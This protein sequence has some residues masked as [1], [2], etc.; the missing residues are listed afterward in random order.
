MPSMSF[1]PCNIENGGEYWFFSRLWKLQ[2]CDSTTSN[3][4]K[5]KKKHRSP[6]PS[7]QVI[8][9][10][11]GMCRE[12]HS[13]ENSLNCKRSGECTHCH[14]QFTDKF[15]KAPRQTFTFTFKGWKH[16]LRHWDTCRNQLYQQI[17]SW[18]AHT[19]DLRQFVAIT[20]SSHT[21]N[22]LSGTNTIYKCSRP[23]WILLP[24]SEWIWSLN[25]IEKWTKIKFIAE[26]N[27]MQ[28]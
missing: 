9:F 10:L 3:S 18:V 25:T 24:L 5:K 2:Y 22:F 4:L 7:Q 20:K 26:A 21:S 15:Q 12:E 27:F 14:V 28:D 13:F 17:C 6:C 23:V 11:W 8:W 19:R 1:F 16:L